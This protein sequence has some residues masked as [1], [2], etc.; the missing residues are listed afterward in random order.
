MPVRSMP[1]TPTFRGRNKPKRA[2]KIFPHSLDSAL[3]MFVI[4][5]VENFAKTRNE[6][7]QM[8]IVICERNH[9]LVCVQTFHLAALNEIVLLFLTTFGTMSAR[10]IDILGRAIL[11]THRRTDTKPIPSIGLTRNKVSIQNLD[12]CYAHIKIK[13]TAN[14]RT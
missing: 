3:N 12:R 4:G 7:W 2:T 1:F 8:F 6:F 9:I 13:I 10:D 5:I 14:N 11:E